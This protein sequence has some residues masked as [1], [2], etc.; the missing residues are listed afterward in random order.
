MKI[1]NK[2]ELQQIVSNHSF[3]NIDFDDFK[4]LYRN[5]TAG[6]YSF[7]VIGTTLPSD[8]RLHFLKNLLE[9]L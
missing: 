1:P 6:P 3:I 8:N 9:E 4:W 7:L 2:E 5:F